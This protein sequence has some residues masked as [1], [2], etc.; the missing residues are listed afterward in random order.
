MCVCVFVS[1]RVCEMGSYEC[2]DLRRVCEWPGSMFGS[3]A[4]VLW[5]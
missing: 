1:V 2:K 4:A 3:D 5:K